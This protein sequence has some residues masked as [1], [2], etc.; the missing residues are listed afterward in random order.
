MRR[1]GLLVF[2]MVVSG[3]L[4]AS[5]NPM[6]EYIKSHNS[7][8]TRLSILSKSGNYP[9]PGYGALVNASLFGYVDIVDKL[10]SN[11]EIVSMEGADALHAAATMGWIGIINILIERGVSPNSIDGNGMSPILGASQFGESVAI[12]NLILHGGDLNY[13]KDYKNTAI[14]LAAI[15][16]D[17]DAV[18]VVLQNGYT[19]TESDIS[20]V[21]NIAESTND[22]K[23]KKVLVDVVSGEYDFSGYEC[24]SP[25]K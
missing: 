4:Y 17:I 21:K 23:L 3:V 15:S 8:E 22:K 1:V 9:V 11:E 16:G 6:W 5:D 20:I 18:H 19:L 14:I 25:T 7:M 12:C 2:L 10:S 24:L 13:K